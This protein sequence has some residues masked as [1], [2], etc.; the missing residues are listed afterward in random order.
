MGG[1]DGGG[2]GGGGVVCKVIFVSNPTRVL[3]LCCVGIGVVTI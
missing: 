3:M 2:D 1:G